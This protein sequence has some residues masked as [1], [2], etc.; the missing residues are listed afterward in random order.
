MEAWDWI[1]IIA[2][3]ISALLVIQGVYLVLMGMEADPSGDE[4]K[5]NKGMIT[6][7]V[8]VAILFV[9]STTQLFF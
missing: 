8:G 4:R 7:I 9:V 1:R 5:F 2:D 6:C 3:I